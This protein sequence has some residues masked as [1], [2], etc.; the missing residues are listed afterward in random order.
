MR[1][2]VLPA[3]AAAA[4]APP[5]HRLP[6]PLLPCSASPLP[7]PADLSEVVT[8]VG[9][10]ETEVDMVDSLGVST[11]RQTGREGGFAPSDVC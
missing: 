8:R 9:L 11:C 2:A 5:A 3:T 10:G 6:R 4:A 1:C 7:C